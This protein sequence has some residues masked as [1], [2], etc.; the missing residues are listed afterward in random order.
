[1]AYKLLSAL[2]SCDQALSFA[3]ILPNW[4]CPAID[5]L[6]ASGFLRNAYTLDKNNHKYVNGAQHVCKPTDMHVLFETSTLVLFLQN[7]KGF[8]RWPPLQE[9]M[10]L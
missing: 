10:D 7:E 2:K 4:E 9:H 1:M 6:K 3:V 8:K 5:I